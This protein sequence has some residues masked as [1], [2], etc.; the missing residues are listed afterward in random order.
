MSRANYIE[1]DAVVFLGLMAY[2]YRN[3]DIQIRHNDGA[4]THKNGLNVFA[5]IVDNNDGELLSIWRNQIHKNY[6]PLLHAEQIVLHEAID[7]IR[8]KY[9]VDKNYISAER[10]YR[11]QMF[12]GD[13]GKNKGCTLYTTLEP[14]PFCT[15]ALLVSR[16]KRIVYILPDR[17]FGGSSK[18]LKARFYDNYDIKYSQLAL[19]C[20]N[21]MSFVT[22]ASHLYS[23][24]LKLRDKVLSDKTEIETLIL[25]YIPEFLA[26][27]S[28]S[29][30][31]LKPSEIIQTLNKSL[32]IEKTFLSL[33]KYL[34]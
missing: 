3:F 9:K 22:K 15:S 25:D 1:L 16:M 29:F 21:E 27:V 5:C 2:A 4:V 30:N 28:T 32:N 17:T 18:I 31:S 12:Y 20:L 19:H 26:D 13:S 10:F 7:N 14:C 6:N 33:K 23:S 34:K 24:L 11:E 8:K